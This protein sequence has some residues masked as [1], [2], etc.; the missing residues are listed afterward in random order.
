[1]VRRC[2]VSAAPRL[3]YPFAV[4]NGVYGSRVACRTGA[5]V[6]QLAGALVLVLRYHARDRPLPHCNDACI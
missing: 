5:S 6:G 3:P 4:P 1:M 2:D